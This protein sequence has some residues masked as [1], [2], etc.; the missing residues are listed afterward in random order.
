M[1][2]EVS[3]QMPST[4]RARRRPAGPAAV[5]TRA[6]LIANPRASSLRPGDLDLA[7]RLLESAFELKT[8]ST[9]GA[10]HARSAAAE[11]AQAGY[12]LVIAL[13]GDGTL[14]EV[15]DGLAGTA[16]PMACLPGGCTNVFAR[17]VGMP[18]RL[19]SAVRRLADAGASGRLPPPRSIDL[20]IVNGR[21]FL[22]SVGIGFS[23]SMTATVNQHPT[24]KAWLGQ[25]H[26]AAAAV[27]QLSGRYLHDPPR[28]VIEAAGRRVEAITA[29]V[30]NGEV[31]T[32]VGPKPIRICP[33]EALGTGT[34]SIAA[35]RD[36]LVSDVPS[37]LAGMLT[38]PVGRV[39]RHPRVAALPNV[40]E[41]VVTAATDEPIPVEADGELLADCT[42]ITLGVAPDALRIVVP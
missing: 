35:V 37:L 16:T 18:R 25:A 42:R 1:A 27:K 23:A 30:Q 7:I 20:G 31:L 2:V 36:L 15:A 26:F 39:L 22:A 5:R 6:L 12:D 8:E 28:M 24:R 33:S 3:T 21:H 10:G 4:D 29:M 17:L 34:I 40:R 11:A 9:L 19:D 13:G 41:A 38:P 14:S 32:Y